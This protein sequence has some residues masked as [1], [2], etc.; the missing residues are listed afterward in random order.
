MNNYINQLLSQ[1][2]TRMSVSEFERH[3]YQIKIEK[4][5]KVKILDEYFR[6]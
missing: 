5:I 1:S 2:I 6:E 3:T 4:S